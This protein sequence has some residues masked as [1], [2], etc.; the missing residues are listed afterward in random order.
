MLFVCCWGFFFCRLA[1]SKNWTLCTP[2]PK[3]VKTVF[4]EVGKLKGVAG[5]QAQVPPL[6]SPADKCELQLQ[7]TEQSE[8]CSYYTRSDL[9]SMECHHAVVQQGDTLYVPKGMVHFAEA[10]EEG[11]IHLTASIQREGR[12]WLD[13]VAD[14]FWTLDDGAAT[15][16][17][18]AAAVKS[19]WLGVQLAKLAP[20]RHGGSSAAALMLLS[21]GGKSTGSSLENA[22]A[23]HL[24]LLLAAV[25]AEVPSSALFP[26]PFLQ[27]VRTATRRR[28]GTD[29]GT[30]FCNKDCDED[31][32]F[33]FIS[34]NEGC[35]K[36]C[37]CKPDHQPTPGG[38]DACS[39]CTSGKH[40]PGENRD[41]CENT[42]TSTT[43]KTTTTY[44]G[45]TSTLTHTTTTSTSTTTVTNTN[46]TTTTVTTTSSTTTN[47]VTTTTNETQAAAAAA[48]V[49]AATAAAEAAEAAE[50]EE[51]EEA[52]G[53]TNGNPS[54]SVGLIAGLCFLGVVLLAIGTF[55]CIRTR[56]CCKSADDP[57]RRRNIN[58]GTQYPVPNIDTTKPAE[59]TADTNIG[60]GITVS[61]ITVTQNAAFSVHEDGADDGTFADT[62]AAIVYAIP[63][64]ISS[65]NNDASP[66]YELAS[67]G[68]MYDFASP[69]GGAGAG[70]YG[71][72]AGA[73]AGDPTNTDSIVRPAD[74]NNVYD[75][76]GRNSSRNSSNIAAATSA[77][78]TAAVAASNIQEDGVNVD[79][80]IKSVH[81][82][83]NIL[84]KSADDNHNNGNNGSQDDYAVANAIC[85]G[86]GGNGDASQSVP[87]YAVPLNREQQQAAGTSVGVG[88][89]GG[90]G[91]GNSSV[92]D[93]PQ[94]SGYA[95]PQQKPQKQQRKRAGGGGE[96]P[97]ARGPKPDPDLFQDRG[98][99]ELVGNVSS[100]PPPLVST[101]IA[102]ALFKQEVRAAQVSR[103][104]VYGHDS[105]A[106]MQAPQLQPQSAPRARA[107]TVYSG[108]GDDDSDAAC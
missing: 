62:A 13:A 8:V 100:A 53:N 93:D 25:K 77:G 89:G 28:K 96:A 68:A 79:T 66:E 67:A 49:A 97:P 50:A 75:K 3:S 104:S 98:G 101:V 36:G 22:L 9:D 51:A 95:P 86:A 55:Y 72:G 102:D 91:G 90:G 30:Y 70:G 20:S 47:T 85:N 2:E 52:A 76:W 16:H 6:L 57:T 105:I 19:T 42:T 34:C 63:V 23:D 21:S 99:I 38:G 24:E 12:T 37:K 10:G 65:G 27:H 58:W 1:G 44:T 74:E 31:C 92:P 78:A 56:K 11:S 39:A 73:G 64:D 88:G 41:V 81:L 15:R 40:S 4:E 35:D 29:K 14:T 103:N 7:D 18:L 82:V 84:Y 5:A 43:T 87:Q 108:F 45:S 107:D 71:A 33:G 60:D 26:A 69:D 46:T 80:R 59:A 17:N 61:A 54:K 106:D 32:Y 48:A 83:P 94:Y